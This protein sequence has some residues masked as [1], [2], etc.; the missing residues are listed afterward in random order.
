MACAQAAGAYYYGVCLCEWRL[1]MR[2]AFVYANGGCLCEWRLSMR[3]AAVCEW[4]SLE[5]DRP[6]HVAV[7]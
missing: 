7:P 6:M 4:Q 1:S 3:M 2:M 5:S